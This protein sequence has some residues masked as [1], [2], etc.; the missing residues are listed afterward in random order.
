MAVMQ[1]NIARLSEGRHTHQFRVAPADLGL[2]ENYVGDVVVDA[3]LD[4]TGRQIIL[5]AW[6]QATGKF[7][8]D[9]CLEPFASSL[10]GHYRILYVPEGTSIPTEAVDGEVQTVPAEAQVIT[11]DEDVRQYVELAVPSKL[12]CRDDCQ[13]LCPRCG[14]NWNTGRCACDQQESDPRWDAL[15]KLTNS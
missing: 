13:G 12:L 6:F 8:C 9:R 5:L 4:R 10:A 11:L 1:V 14:K 7:T 2:G 3:T 15:K